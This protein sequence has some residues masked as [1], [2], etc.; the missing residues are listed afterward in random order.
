MKIAIISNFVAPY[1]IEG[2]GAINVG[3]LV[4]GLSQNNVD[5]V[6]ITTHR[7]RKVVVDFLYPNVKVYKFYP[8]NLFF[9][10]P[11]GGKKIN[12]FIKLLWWIVNLWNPFVFFKVRKILKKEKPDIVNIHS[13]YSLSPAVFTA[14]KSLKLPILYTLHGYFDLCVTSGFFKNGKICWKQC[15]LCWLWSKWNK[16]FLQKVN[17]LFLSKFSAELYK[18]YLN[19][20]GLEILHNPSFLSKEKIKRN[21]ELK[22]KKLESIKEVQF[23]FIGF[24]HYH[25]GVL[26]VIEAFLTGNFKNSKLIVVG[27]GK[28]KNYVKNAE[29]SGKV[30]YVG[31][32]KGEDKES[33]LLNSHVLVFPSEWYECSPMVI[34]EAYAYG[35][36]VI[37]TDI[38]SI[39]E[40]IYIGKTGYTFKYK[41]VNDLQN[42]IRI[43]DENPSKI[44]EMS[45]NCFEEAIKNCMESYIKKYIEILSK[46]KNL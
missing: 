13:Y 46:V 38:G 19:V 44:V 11:P 8:M 42:Y 40:H 1:Y 23:L 4:I 30:K 33:L 9:N 18:K 29:K 24:L 34:Q 17:F 31:F 39:P 36:P 26:T 25:K 28:L 6:L 14:A 27:D 20:S 7:Q 32:A 37:G 2:G 21:K 22:M 45:L 16:I 43:F 12:K 35:L 15:R 5:V 10:F 3:N 41:D